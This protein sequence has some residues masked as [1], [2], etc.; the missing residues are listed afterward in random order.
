MYEELC[1]SVGWC[2][3]AD[4]YQSKPAGFIL[5]AG[6]TTKHE[7]IIT[8]DCHQEMR[9]SNLSL[10]TT[11]CPEKNIMAVSH[12]AQLNTNFKLYQDEALLSNLDMKI[13]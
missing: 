7:L 3:V 2:H 1:L 10:Q 6:H 8:L 11:I 5:L 9:L 12:T 4:V 13:K